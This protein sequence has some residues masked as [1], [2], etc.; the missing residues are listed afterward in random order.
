MCGIAF[1]HQNKELG[2]ASKHAFRLYE[3]QKKRGTQGYGCV[4][5]DNGK[6]DQVYRSTLESGIRKILENKGNLAFFHHRTPTSAPNIDECNHPILVSHSSLDHDYYVI[7]NGMINNANALKLKYNKIGY[8]YTTE[9]SVAYKTRKNRYEDTTETEFNDTE[10]FAIDLAIA[11]DEG[12]T[13]LESTGAIA[14]MALRVDKETGKIV[15]VLF[16]RNERNPLKIFKDQ[17][18]FL[19]SS[20]G[21]GE[22]VE[23][24][25]LFS[26]DPKTREITE[27]SFW[28]DKYI[29]P[30]RD[31][32][33]VPF[34]PNKEYNKTEQRQL[35]DSRNQYKPS[36]KGRE[37][38]P[39][40]VSFCGNAG[41]RTTIN[42]S[43]RGDYI[44]RT[45]ILEM[46]ADKL[47]E[48]EWTWYKEILRTVEDY[49]K[50]IKESVT[51]NWKQYW[52]DQTRKKASEFK[53]LTGVVNNRPTGHKEKFFGKEITIVDEEEII[54]RE[55]F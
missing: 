46:D 12:K 13:T 24:H 22:D 30:I 2:R 6:I 37:L 9:V 48:G 51:P 15:S 36:R 27:R 34:T 7:H 40:S 32:E 41:V 26:Y 31:K 44:Y 16:G 23:C 33:V 50:K 10:S 14:F 39:S 25:K 11:V 8:D 54:S 42:F 55:K 21:A 45:G 38:I 35:F 49:E 47:F 19:V 5:A 17:K 29:P 28:I 4:M 53:T 18:Q 1:V 3:A 20:E 52:I 43:V